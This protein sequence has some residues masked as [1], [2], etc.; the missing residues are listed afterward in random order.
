M[1][2][3]RLTII[4]FSLVVIAFAV[5]VF[6]ALFSVK[7]VD[8]KFSVYGE[9]VAGAEELLSRY[10]GKNLLFIDENEVESTIKSGLAVKV[11][12]VKKVYPSTLEISLA[13]RQERFAIEKAGGGYYV[14]DD[15]YFVVAER[16]TA[17]NPTDGPDNVVVTFSQTLYPEM[18]V[19]ERLAVEENAALSAFKAAVDK[20]S[21]PRDEIASVSVYEMQER[22]NVR[23]SVKLRTGVEILILKAYESA[24]A[25]MAAAIAKLNELEDKDKIVGKIECYQRDDGTIAAVYTTH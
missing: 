21:C 2:Y 20:F 18:K 7:D 19:N 5:L 6:V 3:K 23:I 16:D 17:A 15:E 4:L 1:S 10:E 11:V 13:V 8:I 25:K 22:G 24:G 14:A 9:R 12:Y